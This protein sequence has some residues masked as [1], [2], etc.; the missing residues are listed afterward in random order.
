MMR[1]DNATLKARVKDIED[2][3]REEQLEALVLYANGSTLGS[4]N[5]MHG[6]LRYLCNFDGHN[7]PAMLVL[8]PGH[9][10]SLVSAANPFLL[11]IQH[12]KLLWFSDVR[13]TKAPLM[14]E[15]IVAILKKPNAR[16]RRIGYMGL[17]E[18]P[19][20]V[21]TA[22]NKGLPSVE[23]VD[24]SPTFDKRRVQKTDL[25]MA[26]HRR[27]AEICDA[28][29]QTVRREVRTGLKGYELQAEM[30]RTARQEGAEYCVTWLTVEPRADYPRF[31]KEECTRVPMEG[32]QVIPGIYMTYD[33]HWGHAIRT[34]TVGQPTDDHK[35]IYDIVREMHQACLDRLKPGENLFDAVEA[36]DKVLYKYYSEEK[37]DR[38]RAGHGLGLSYEDPIVSSA[39]FHPWEFKNKPHGANQLEIKPSMLLE[40]HPNL[41][42]PGV[43]GA[44]VGD[45]VAITDSGYEVLTEFPPDLIIW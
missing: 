3:L 40:V 30:E 4:F 6:Y 36:M 38:S 34:G 2:A 1:I 21:W 11:R 18:T 44:M 15:E 7:T 32:D 41:F 35:R 14:G 29:F 19:V 39:F 43:A 33:G 24:F 31:Y 16:S 8:R 28:I 45:M 9:E 20:P 10:P 12:H 26:F 23:W 27:A 37:S 5:K 17:N 25:Q 42:I 22:I 13:T